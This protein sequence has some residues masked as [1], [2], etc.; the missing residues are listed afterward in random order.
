MK[1]DQ[2]SKLE[3]KLATIFNAI[4]RSMRG[5]EGVAMSVKQ[6]IAK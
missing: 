4:P 1:A 5:M 3:F 2:F 6:S